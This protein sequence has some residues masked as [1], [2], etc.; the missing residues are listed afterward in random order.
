MNY[1]DPELRA[2]LAADYVAGAMR[3][4]ARRR[5]EG[6]MAADANLRRQVREWE[7][8]IY[9][10]L[11]S[12]PARVPPRR[13]W[14]AIESRLKPGGARGRQGLAFWRVLSGALAAVL[15]AGVVVYP[16]QVDRA[17]RTQLMAVLQSP[18]AQ[19]MLVVRADER[20]GLHVQALQD[21]ASRAGGKA[22][23]LWVIPPGQAPQSVG[24]V[25]PEGLTA[26]PRAQ[27]LEGVQTL[28]ITLE[29]PGG[30]PSGKPTGP[31]IMSGDVL[32]I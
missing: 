6:L 24:L 16:M 1:S 22:L 4:G 26:L 20:G 28:A 13:V 30:S 7:D 15:V 25:A 17:A 32:K 5:F 19:A 8:D 23:E 9:P 10:L 29:P 12:L 3:G 14:R 31:V 27:G 2:R 18:E 11:W 21:L